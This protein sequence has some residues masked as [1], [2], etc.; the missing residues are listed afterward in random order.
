M[1][2]GGDGGHKRPW[3]LRL[4]ETDS[5]GRNVCTVLWMAILTHKPL[6]N[7]L[8]TELESKLSAHPSN[9][10]YVVPH[11]GVSWFCL[12]LSMNWWCGLSKSIC[13]S[14][15]SRWFF[16]LKM[17]LCTKHRVKHLTEITSIFTTS[18]EVGAVI[19]FHRSA[20]WDL[21]DTANIY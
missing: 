1:A 20:N 11:E 4:S 17:F 10:C 19:P 16:T 14:V 7:M 15:I 21:K 12:F 18:Q 8:M 13:K 2:E 9:L 6:R 5:R 3:A